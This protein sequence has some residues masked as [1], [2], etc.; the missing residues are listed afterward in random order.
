MAAPA[1]KLKPNGD[2]ADKAERKVSPSLII[3]R[4]ACELAE[5]ARNTWEI[6]MPI[7][8][9][10][11][12][13][14]NPNALG[15]IARDLRHKDLIYAQPSD[16]AWLAIYR[17]LAVDVSRVQL[18][19]LQQFKLPARVAH[20]EEDPPGY[21]IDRDDVLGWHVI[22]LADNVMMDCGRDNRELRSWEACRRFIFDHPTH[23]T[24]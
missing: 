21:K 12:D 3:P 4:S 11:E 7:G 14:V 8:S 22:R 23:R 16:A 17:V 20:G 6:A 9:T 24:Q 5:A 18:A 10:P 13:L 15:P 19:L 1:A 2:A